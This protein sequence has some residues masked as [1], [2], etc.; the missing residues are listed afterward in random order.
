MGDAETNR[1]DGPGIRKIPD[2]SRN[3]PILPFRGVRGPPGG[4]GDF[5]EGHPLTPTDAQRRNAK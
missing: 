4:P 2:S 5:P 3:F 1:K